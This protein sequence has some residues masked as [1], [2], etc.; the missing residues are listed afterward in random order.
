VV[1]RLTSILALLLV[2]AGCGS[3]SN[4]MPSDLCVNRVVNAVLTVDAD[5]PRMVW[6]TNAAGIELAIR[7]PGGYGVTPDD[8]IVNA[9]GRVIAATGDRIVGGCGDL[10]Q[11][12]LLITETNI[13]RE[14]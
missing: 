11:N 14:P 4:A 12:A 6:A 8:E 13:R 10:L 2:I 3:G 1:R 9:D 5:D 7:L